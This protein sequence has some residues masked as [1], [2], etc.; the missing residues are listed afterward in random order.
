MTV[1]LD[2]LGAEFATDTPQEI[3]QGDPDGEQ[4]PLGDILTA[5]DTT[6]L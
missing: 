4:S 1:S 6:P 3:K 2:R 5:Q